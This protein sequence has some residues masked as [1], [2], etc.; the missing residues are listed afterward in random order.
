MCLFSQ[1]CVS[2]RVHVECVDA[3]V[4]GRQVHVLEHL[5]Q[6]VS[7]TVL[8]AH[9]LVRVF[10]H[11]SLDEAQEMLLVH[12]GRGVDVCVHLTEQESRQQPFLLELGTQAAFTNTFTFWQK[13]ISKDFSRSE[14]VFFIYNLNLRNV[15]LKIMSC[16]LNW[17]GFISVLILL[18]FILYF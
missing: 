15:F 4:I 14:F 12:A 17:T 11:R 10:L 2:Y 9:D 8:H 7:S 16:I 13:L 18:I 1:R 3:E 5:H 6:C